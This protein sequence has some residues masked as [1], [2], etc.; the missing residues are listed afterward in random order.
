MPEDSS[1]AQV[2]TRPTIGRNAVHQ[3]SAVLDESRDKKDSDI[4]K[5]IEE[6][7]VPI[8]A[9]ML[10][11]F[12]TSPEPGE[13]PFVEIGTEVEQDTT[14]CIIEVMK[15][16]SSISAGISGRIARICAEDGQLVE[17]DKVLFLV[18]PDT[19]E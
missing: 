7:L 15:L 17:Y 1:A 9:P 6:G 19:N 11:T 5:A 8:K 3:D 2:H 16:F 12:Y 14:I 10:G 18:D 13:P 4:E